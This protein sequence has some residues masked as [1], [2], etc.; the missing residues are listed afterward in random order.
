MH[1]HTT[2]PCDTGLSNT[3]RH[4]TTA[5]HQSQLLSPHMNKDSQSNLWYFSHTHK[6]QLG[7]Y[8]LQQQYK[9]Y[10]RYNAYTVYYTNTH[11]VFNHLFIHWEYYITH[12]TCNNMQCKHLNNYCIFYWHWFDKLVILYSTIHAAHWD[13][14]A[15]P[16]K[17]HT[18]LVTLDKVLLLLLF[19]V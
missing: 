18:K 10:H 17:K 14:T 9:F 6:H 13:Y 2:A 4:T 16:R 15:C 19:N 5:Y 8:K 11:S 1:T 7:L 12:S 3:Y